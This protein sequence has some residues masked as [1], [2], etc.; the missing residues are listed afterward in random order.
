MRRT[1]PVLCFDWGEED[2]ADLV[3]T[4]H[5]DLVT[6]KGFDPGLSAEGREETRGRVLSVIVPSFAT[7]YGIGPSE[8]YSDVFEQVAD[9]AMRLA[10]DHIFPDGNKRTT[11]VMSLGLLRFAGVSLLIEDADDPQD[12][13]V[14][15]WIQDVVT[16]K[17]TRDELAQ[18][19]RDRSR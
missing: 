3:M 2:L 11:V 13:E 4:V 19:L 14:Y 1:V 18:A 8:R 12:N 10:N 7:V 5:D 15:K 17:K 9:F 16:K 6:K